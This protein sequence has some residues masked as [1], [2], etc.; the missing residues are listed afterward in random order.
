MTDIKPTPALFL[1]SPPHELISLAILEGGG[2]PWEHQT[3]ENYV[4][5]EHQTL[6]TILSLI[7]VGTKCCVGK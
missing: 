7:F 5:W 6:G 2:C 4:P 3:H 1:A